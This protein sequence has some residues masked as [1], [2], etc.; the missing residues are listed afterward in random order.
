MGTD[1][2]IG[3][4]AA[5]E[6]SREMD[7][8]GRTPALP[9]VRTLPS[10][11]TRGIGPLGAKRMVQVRWRGKRVRVGNARIAESHD[12]APSQRRGHVWARGA[13]DI[14][15]VLREVD[16]R[17]AAGVEVA[18]R[19]GRRMHDVRRRDGD[20]VRRAVGA[21][22]AAALPA[23]VLPK[24]EGKRAAADGALADLRVGL[25]GREHVLLAWV[26][27]SAI[28]VQ[29]WRVEL[30]RRHFGW[31]GNRQGVVG[32]VPSARNRRRRRTQA[33]GPGLRGPSPRQR[34]ASLLHP[35]PLLLCHGHGP[36]KRQAPL[37][38]IRVGREVA[39]ERPPHLELVTVRLLQAAFRVGRTHRRS[40]PSRLLSARVCGSP[41]IMPPR[42]EQIAIAVAS[43]RGERRMW[44][45]CCWSCRIVDVGRGGGS[46]GGDVRS[47]GRVRGC[48]G[49]PIH[50]EWVLKPGPLR[51]ALSEEQ[52]VTLE[53]SPPV[54]QLELLLG[55]QLTILR[56]T[57][58]EI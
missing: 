35:P 14:V 21:D 16:D 48:L 47:R 52:V 4:R 9:C 34:V 58:V 57:V 39:Q 1:V 44:G 41:K 25:P 46:Y 56:K 13:G 20:A 51:R 27:G 42:V 54:V 40:R 37:R 2:G 24:P 17:D 26:F 18:D 32:V 43:S 3:R 50:A 30:L 55:A 31:T 53:R 23:V 11:R 5:G 6:R 38:G 33:R 45:L 7:L 49:G 22:D 12:L 36:L 19:H 10:R 8:R 15:F 29:S 28:S